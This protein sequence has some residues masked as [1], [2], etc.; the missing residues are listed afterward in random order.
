MVL[1]R[2]PHCVTCGYPFFGSLEENTG[3]AHCAELDPLFREGR[4]AGLFQGPLRRL[5]HALKYEG[6]V[7]L[8]RD[9]EAVVRANTHFREFL[10]GAV[11]VPVPLHPRKQR[12]RGF[13]Q[14]HLLAEAFATAS[15]GL[16]VNALM[17][18]VLD[19]PTQT[20]LDREQRQSN[21]KN[22]FALADEPEIQPD[23]RYVLVDDV[24]TTG[25]TLNACAKVLRRAGLTAID[26]A[27]FGHG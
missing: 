6:A 3:C 1:A 23:L 2:E 5:V 20:R 14:A 26:V 19:T 4:T 25:A 15:G 16:S 17:K 18:R 22:A 9:V 21:L 27:T 8:V 10:V 12:E 13:N 24:F 7:H 11:L